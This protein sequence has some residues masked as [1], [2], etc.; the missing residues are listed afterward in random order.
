MAEF[1]PGAACT[2]DHTTAQASVTLFTGNMVVQE[3]DMLIVSRG[4]DL[5]PLRTY[6]GQGRQEDDATDNWLG[7][8]QAMRLLLSGSAGEADS[9]VIRID[10]DGARTR[11]H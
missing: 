6:N 5:V 10:Q 4:E 11:Y 2:P 8:V 3:Y 7:G 1:A 9:L